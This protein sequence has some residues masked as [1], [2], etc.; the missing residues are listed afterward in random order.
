MED[1]PQFF[2]F[3]STIIWVNLNHIG[4]KLKYHFQKQSLWPK[5]TVSRLC[6]CFVAPKYL[7]LASGI[8][9]DG[10]K[11]LR[12]KA[13]EVPVLLHR[14]VCLDDVTRKITRSISVRFCCRHMFPPSVPPFQADQKYVQVL[15]L[16]PHPAAYHNSLRMP[17]FFIFAIPVDHLL[18][19]SCTK[20][21]QISINRNLRLC[22][23]SSRS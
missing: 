15:H 13:C 2:P 3:I 11:E 10:V 18:L 12:A 19:K 14:L 20:L 5:Q 17:L 6:C 9:P 22:F 21:H 4:L 7:L 16:L 8:V 1:R 23:T